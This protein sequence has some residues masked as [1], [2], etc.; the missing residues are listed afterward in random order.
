MSTLTNLIAYWRMDEASGDRRDSVGSMDMQYAGG[1]TPTAVTGKINNG[2]Q[3]P[4]SGQISHNPNPDLVLSADAASL[5]GWIRLDSIGTTE[6]ASLLFLE[7]YDGSSTFRSMT[8]YYDEVEEEL[9]LQ[10]MDHD[11]SNTADVRGTAFGPLT[12]GVWYHVALLW[13]NTTATLVINGVTHSGGAYSPDF[14]RN[15]SKVVLAS[16]W[17]ISLDEWGLWD[18]VISGTDLS[19]LYNSGSGAVPPGLGYPAGSAG[20]AAF[21]GFH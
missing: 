16:G 20:N 2:V 13:N 7:V 1:G 9:V 6:F 11:T 21:F 12:E 5:A 8:L 17:P 15:I 19:D 10:T 3:I 14:N 4:V 18:E